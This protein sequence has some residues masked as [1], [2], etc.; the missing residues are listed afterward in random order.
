MAEV[1]QKKKPASKSK[2]FEITV[3]KKEVKVEGPKTTGLQIKEAAIAQGVMIEVDFQLAEIK[4]SGERIII[5]NDDPVKLHKDSQF[6]A[7]A[8][9]DN[10]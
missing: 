5:G 8:P 7:T 4:A 6:V 10:S 9:D 2:L 3:N 1:T